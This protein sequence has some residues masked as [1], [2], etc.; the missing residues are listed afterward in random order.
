M[1]PAGVKNLKLALFENQNFSASP[2]DLDFGSI[3]RAGIAEGWQPLVQVFSRRSGER[4]Y[5]FA[6][7]FGKDVKLLVATVE[8]DEAVVLQAKVNPEKLNCF[9]GKWIEKPDKADQSEPAPPDKAPDRT[10]GEILAPA[11]VQVDQQETLLPDA[12]TVAQSKGLHKQETGKS[13][14]K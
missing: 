3:V 14:A 11:S 12:E 5:V 2:N 8:E 4:T 10:R 9:I 13:G 7:D 6:Q 1:G